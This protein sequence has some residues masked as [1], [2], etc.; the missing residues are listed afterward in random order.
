MNEKQR[1]IR[2]ILNKLAA[3]HRQGLIDVAAAMTLVQEDDLQICISTKET[4]PIGSVPSL[5]VF[6]D[7]EIDEEANRRLLGKLDAE[8]L[9][10]ERKEYHRLK[11]KYE[12]E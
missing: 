2:E 9:R 3:Y 12:H 10:F 4:M 11:A 5:S 7:E 6:T 8:S 1:R